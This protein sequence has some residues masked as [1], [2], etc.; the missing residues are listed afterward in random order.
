M[1]TVRVNNEYWSNGTD[2]YRACTYLMSYSTSSTDTAT[3]VSIDSLTIENLPGDMR[4]GYWCQLKIGG[5]QIDRVF[6][7]S[8][9]VFS[10]KVKTYSRTTSDQLV[11]VELV[12]EGPRITTSGTNTAAIPHLAS[13]SIAY[14]ANGGSGAPSTQTKYYG[15]NI[16]LSSSKPTRA[17]YVFVNWNTKA[18]GTGTT[19]NPGDTYT[20]NAALTLY[21]QW[22]EP[23]YIRYDANG[24]SGAPA[25]QVHVYNTTSTLSTIEP[26]R[27]G[28]VFE[29]WNTEPHGWG[30]ISLNPGGS[31]GWNSDLYLY[32]IW[33]SVPV[34]GSLT[35]YRCDANGDA[36]D[37]GEYGY[38][39]VLWSCDNSNEIDA[40]EVSG[41]IAPQTGG[42]AS[43]IEF[44]GVTSGGGGLAYAVIPNIDTDMQYTISV[45]V[46]NAVNPA[47]AATR[48]D[49]I[50][51]A[52]FI[53][54]FKAGG[55]GLGIG[56]AAPASGLEVNYP[57]VFDQVVN[58]RDQLKFNGTRIYPTFATSAINDFTA[59]TTPCFALDTSTNKMYWVTSGSRILVFDGGVLN[60][61]YFVSNTQLP[62]IYGSAPSSPSYSAISRSYDVAGN[63][64]GYTEG[65]HGVDGYTGVN[66]AAIRS[67]NGSNVY[68]SL[69]LAIGPNG[70]RYLGLN[71]ANVE[72]NGTLN[73]NGPTN[74]TG[75]TVVKGDFE[76]YNIIDFHGGGNWSADYTTRI[77][78][79][80]NDGELWL[81]AANGAPMFTT[82][83]G[84]SPEIYS[85]M[86]ADGEG[87]N[88]GWTAPNG[89]YNEMDSWSNTHTR[90]YNYQS[91]YHA[92]VWERGRDY[93]LSYM[94]AWTHLAYWTGTGQIGWDWSDYN[95]F[96][97]VIL[98]DSNYLG[99]AVI[100]RDWLQ[101]YAREVYTGGGMYSAGGQSGRFAVMS[102]SRTTAKLAVVT[103]DSA[104]VT[105]ACGAAIYGRR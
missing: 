85:K 53:M 82:Y 88:F 100:Q 104:D 98:R 6:F 27:D 102:I 86:Y 61:P 44:S 45:K 103:V 16:A 11:N 90:I 70:E 75:R 55:D 66:Y 65:Y 9:K 92:L 10:G 57:T 43:A 74:I 56:C 83:R 20:A 71:S 54:D 41:T 105:G 39:G 67:I 93:N 14:N 29:I 91:G 28:Y 26:H 15:N 19:Y 69:L 68:S 77:V 62:N 59:P 64:F 40:G 89:T 60:S 18:D 101:D 46:E 36:A 17:N 3:T 81:Q 58:F 12:V 96:L 2:S 97:V 5:V 52:F 8:P 31:Y 24:G 30:D 63:L 78:A 94:H 87:G 42:S 23:Y 47:I 50:T 35:C 51:R 7:D 32:A 79:P 73:V 13:Y 34:I 99:T 21:A 25:T 72:V 84:G 49:I 1:A 37:E 48:N 38:V 4:Q 95:E 33:R 76:V 22:H 80:R